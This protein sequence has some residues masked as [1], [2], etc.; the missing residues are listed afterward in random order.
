MGV[1]SDLVHADDR[2]GK[3]WVVS[4]VSNTLLRRVLY[5]NDRMSGQENLM[6]PFMCF[7]VNFRLSRP[8]KVDYIRLDNRIAIK[9][10]VM[11]PKSYPSIQTLLSDDS[12]KGSCPSCRTTMFG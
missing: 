5:S 4:V 2:T 1:E 7:L 3:R 9:N 6:P 8:K 12:D 11:I 10:E